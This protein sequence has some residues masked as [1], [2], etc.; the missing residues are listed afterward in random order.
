[1]KPA[2]D[3]RGTAGPWLAAAVSGLAAAWSVQAHADSAGRLTLIEEN[4]SF[5]SY[6]DKHYTQ[7]LLLSYLTP[8]LF[9]DSGWAGAY[10]P[11]D[12]LDAILPADIG[13]GERIRRA[14]LGLGQSLFT[15]AD[16][17]YQIPDANDRP[18]GAWL[19]GVLRLLEEDDRRFFQCLELQLGVVGPAALGRQAQNGIHFVLEQPQGEGWLY[20][21]RNEPGGIL[22]YD[23]QWKAMQLHLGDWSVDLMPEADLTAGNIFTYGAIGGILRIGQNIGVDYGPSRIRPAISGYD[24]FLGRR[25]ARGFGFYLFGSTQERLVARNIFLDGNTVVRPSAHVQGRN[26][27][28]L[29]LSAGF[30]LY[31]L[32]GLRLDMAYTV[33]QE[34]FTTQEAADTFGNINLA[35]QL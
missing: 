14:S 10:A 32:G 8:E 28:V 15:P 3:W 17:H 12:W 25:S 13:H 31:W 18:Y 19:Y 11:L 20:Q 35:L 5:V 2:G 7:G 16:L 34:E 9:D 26:W 6:Q 1:L 27:Q 30:S 23:V 22:S 33:R 21:I 24:Y 4:D 29:D